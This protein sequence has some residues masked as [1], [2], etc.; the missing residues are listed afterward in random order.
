M[1]TLY[2]TFHRWAQRVLLI[3][4]IELDKWHDDWHLVEISQGRFCVRYPDGKRST[5]F[6]YRTAKDYA[7]LF[8]GKVIHLSTGRELDT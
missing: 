6:Y 7:E 2:W 5:R 3:L 1:P 4:R 8:G